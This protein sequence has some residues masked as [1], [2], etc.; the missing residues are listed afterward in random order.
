[1]CFEI[2]RGGVEGQVTDEE[3]LAHGSSSFL[4]HPGGGRLGPLK[5][6]PLGTLQAGCFSPRRNGGRPPARECLAAPARAR[7]VT[8][9]WPH[10]SATG[11]DR[12]RSSPALPQGSVRSGPA[13]S[14][15][16]G[17]TSC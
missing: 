11:T 15:L 5:A 3:L 1:Q 2:C 7:E 14:R 10:P 8:R 6:H 9:S 4:C 16:A 12:A 17:W 13:R